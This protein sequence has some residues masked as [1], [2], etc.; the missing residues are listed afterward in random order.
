MRYFILFACLYC[1]CGGGTS[2]PPPET[3]APEQAAQPAPSAPGPAPSSASARAERGSTAAPEPAKPGASP[4]AAAK[5]PEPKPAQPVRTGQVNVEVVGL[6]NTRGQLEVGLYRSAAG[7]PD[8]PKRA[9]ASRRAA[10][11]GG[12]VRVEFDAVPAGPFAVAVHHDENGNGKMDTK[13]FG[14]PDEGYG[15]SRD[16]PVSFG[17]PKFDDARLTLAPGE[18]TT[19]VVRMRY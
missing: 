13:L 4:S 3:G 17:P 15:F 14:Q 16:A 6:S 2:N 5:Q 7:F 19:I 1:A 18:R 9:F 8:D 11:S 10:I 12:R